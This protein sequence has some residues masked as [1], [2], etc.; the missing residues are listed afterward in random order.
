METC[1]LI[2]L[3]LSAYV[4]DDPLAHGKAHEAEHRLEEHA[5][6]ESVS[7][8]DLKAEATDQVDYYYYGLALY[9]VPRCSSL[10]HCRADDGPGKENQCEFAKQVVSLVRTQ[11]QTGLACDG[12][13]GRVKNEPRDDG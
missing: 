7:V 6:A 3:V 2:F 10:A 5:A 9:R 13:P 4:G 8:W 1:P 12:G 11:I